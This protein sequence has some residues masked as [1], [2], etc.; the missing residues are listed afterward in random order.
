MPSSTKKKNRRQSGNPSKR[1]SSAADF[2]K[3]ITA[4]DL[5][6][7]SGNTVLANRIGMKSFLETGT[8]PDYLTPIV[9]KII[10]EKQFLPPEKEKELATD[11]QAIKST[12]EMLDRALVLTVVQPKVHMPPGCEVCGK[13]LDYNDK[14][15][16][17]RK[18]DKFDHDF[19]QEER[20]DDLLYADEVD[21][22]DKMFIFNWSVGGGTD[23]TEFREQLKE[24]VERMAGFPDD[25]NSPE[26]VAGD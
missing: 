1:I 13:Y 10:R 26:P 17:N 19:I 16:H 21:M 12:Q 6:L 5:D 24:S 9:Q 14:D 15:V 22:E 18:G 23:L 7:P 2:K 20:D 8:I 4:V 25:E 3:Q 11:P